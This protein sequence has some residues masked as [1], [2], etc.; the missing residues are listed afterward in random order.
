MS[1]AL[2]TTSPVLIEGQP[3]ADFIKNSIQNLQ[4]NVTVPLGDNRSFLHFNGNTGEWKLNKEP[5]D[6]ASLGRI[7]IAP[8]AIFE[9]MVEWANQKPLQKTQRPLLGVEHKEPM[10][11]HLLPRP[12]SPTAYRQQ[13]D[14]PRYV[15]G[16]AGKMM[17]D[18]TK[19]TFAHSSQGV[20]R[21]VNT[22]AMLVTQASAA[23]GEIVHPVVELGVSS[24][25]TSLGK[26]VFDPQFNVIGYITDKRA[27]EVEA[28]SDEDIL[29]QPSTASRARPHPST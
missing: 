19:L 2:K 26:T 25:L 4:R 5:V 17:D 6:A 11:E 23:F 15:L 21:A 1:Q 9:G 28:L 3:V 18:G 12:L 7:I 10:S 24:Y 16:F 8:D 29:T 20:T 13:S 27:K 14:G 22:L